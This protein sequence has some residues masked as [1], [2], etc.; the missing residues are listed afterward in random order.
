[1]P[2][3]TY[4]EPR[5]KVRNPKPFEEQKIMVYYTVKRK[6]HKEAT[7]AIKKLCQQWR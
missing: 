3:R 1:M 4:N 6:H 7:E 2:K 5:Y